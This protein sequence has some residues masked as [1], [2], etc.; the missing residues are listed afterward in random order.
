M[1]TAQTVSPE[2][3]RYQFTEP[4]P[5]Q[6]GEIISIRRHIM[7][8][9]V[10]GRMGGH[11]GGLAKGQLGATSM[12]ILKHIKQ[13]PHMLSEQIAA[14]LGCDKQLIR[15]TLTNLTKKRLVI[16]TGIKK[17]FRYTVAK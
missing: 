12:E 2:T 8:D 7:E 15:Q 3:Y 11:A 16:R 13:H 17:H 9:T 10:S 14:K 4:L 5:V 6:Y 1:N